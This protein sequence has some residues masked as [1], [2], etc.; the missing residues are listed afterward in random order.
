MTRLLLV[1]AALVVATPLY[2]QPVPEGD[3]I[4]VR[5]GKK[6][7]WVKGLYAGHD[8]T[9]LIMVEDGIERVYELVALERVD[10]HAPKNVVL[11][12]VIGVAGGVLSAVLMGA[13]IC[14]DEF[15]C[16][17]GGVESLAVIFGAIGGGVALLDYA[18]WPRTWK[19]VTKHYPPAGTQQN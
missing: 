2:C 11:N 18:I 13:M 10:W 14:S 7:P 5:E 16:E 4:R 1:L 9:S 6:V 3:E 12:T 17:E 8:S 19:K 15:E